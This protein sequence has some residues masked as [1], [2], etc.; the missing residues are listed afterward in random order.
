M[1]VAS[2][3]LNQ[4]VVLKITQEWLDYTAETQAERGGDFVAFHHSASIKHL[5]NEVTQEALR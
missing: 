1:M 5:Q 4:V 3:D 2:P